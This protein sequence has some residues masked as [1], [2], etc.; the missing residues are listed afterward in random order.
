MLCCFIIRLFLFWLTTKYRHDHTLVLLKLTIKQLEI[1][2]NS[3]CLASRYLVK[4][5]EPRNDVNS[6]RRSVEHN[7]A[8]SPFAI[9][10]KWRK[11]S[12]SQVA[13]EIVGSEVA[14]EVHQ[15]G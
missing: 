4:P 12:K 8:R 15:M 1:V 13:K 3:S 11:F 2:Q 5:A 7:C 6:K 10:N 9:S 14:K